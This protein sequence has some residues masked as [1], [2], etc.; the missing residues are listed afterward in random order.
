MI[1]TILLKDK[2]VYFTA[3]YIDEAMTIP[4]IETFIYLGIDPEVGHLFHD[5]EDETIQC[6]F[7]LEGESSL[8]SINN[9]FDHK[10]LVEWLVDDVAEMTFE[11]KNL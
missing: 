9:I 5:A 3:G 4:I 2:G 6:C 7:P 11:Y 10:G 8:E 1:R